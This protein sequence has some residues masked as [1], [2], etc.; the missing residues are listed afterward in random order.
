M[1]HKVKTRKRRDGQLERRC[2]AD[3]CK[4]WV[5]WNKKTRKTRC[6]EH[7]NRRLERLREARKAKHRTWSDSNL[8]DKDLN[9][10]GT[11][12]NWFKS[13]NKQQIEALNSGNNHRLLQCP[14]RPGSYPPGHLKLKKQK[15]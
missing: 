6:L 10:K 8:L 7:D 14:D 15:R 12:E 3:G 2:I 9:G 13:C 5:I 11:Q 4:K 1:N